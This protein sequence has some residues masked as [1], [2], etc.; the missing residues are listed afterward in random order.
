MLPEYLQSNILL[1]V[2][3]PE[4]MDYWKIHDLLKKQ[5][6]VIYSG[7][8]NLDRGIFRIASLGHINEKNI[9]TFLREFKKVLTVCINKTI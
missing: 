4:N 2:K 8:K 9:K 1:A 3:L 7:Q 6:F 5:G